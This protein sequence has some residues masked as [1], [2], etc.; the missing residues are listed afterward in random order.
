MGRPPRRHPARGRT[1]THY[2]RF[3]CIEST[4]RRVLSGPGAETASP[5]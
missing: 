3:V 4:V 5:T 2:S 1:Y